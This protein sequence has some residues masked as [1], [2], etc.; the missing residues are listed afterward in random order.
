MFL[1][2]ILSP[3]L[4]PIV[5]L[6]TFLALLYLPFDR[7]IYNKYKE[8]SEKDKNR[9]VFCGRLGGYHYWEMQE[10]IKSA[11]ELSRYL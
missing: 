2:F 4:I 11:L 7:L 6:V 3:I 10:V 8:L 9:V 1:L 5:I